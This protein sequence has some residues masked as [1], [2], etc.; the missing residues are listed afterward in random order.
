MN[1]LANPISALRKKRKQVDL[2]MD[3]YEEEQTGSSQDTKL[4]S[5][6]TASQSEETQTKCQKTIK[7]LGYF[8]AALS[9]LS[10]LLAMMY[11]PFILLSPTKF[12]TLFSVAL[13]SSALAL[14][15]LKGKS[16]IGENLL[17]GRVRYY[18]VTLAATNVIGLVASFRDSGAIVC[19]VMAIAQFVS[20][21]YVLFARLQYGKEFLD[22]FYGGIATFFGGLV[23]RVFRR[24][25]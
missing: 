20:L 11:L 1:L 17:S 5:G 12:C 16:Y 13:A 23:G 2:T 3:S 6:Y 9:M 15:C 19:L 4:T 10:G 22:N 14:L 8:W 7:A 25:N 18:T 24:T 21:T